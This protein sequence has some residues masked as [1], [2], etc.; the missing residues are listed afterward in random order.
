MSASVLEASAA[1][2][3]ERRLLAGAVA[4]AMGAYTLLGWSQ[5]SNIPMGTLTYGAALAAV[6]AVAHLVLRRRAPDADPVLLPAAFLL[7]GLGLVLWTSPSR[8]T[9][10]LRTR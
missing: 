4:L 9:S 10:S 3:A 5:S 8:T 1:A 2:A 7:N 6:A